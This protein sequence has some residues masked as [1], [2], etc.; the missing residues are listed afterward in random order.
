MNIITCDDLYLHTVRC[1][2]IV[3]HLFLKCYMITPLLKFHDLHPFLMYTPTPGVYAHPIFNC[4]V[5]SLAEGTTAVG[6][7]RSERQSAE[8]TSS[9]SAPALSRASPVI[10]ASLS[11]KTVWRVSVVVLSRFK[12]YSN[13]MPRASTLLAWEDVRVGF[14]SALMRVVALTAPST[15]FCATVWRGL[16][17]I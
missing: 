4:V 12:R 11:F 8:C 5:A 2:P 16:I 6:D 13:F 7:G 1:T 9:G 17:G 10:D 14:P 3:L 15:S